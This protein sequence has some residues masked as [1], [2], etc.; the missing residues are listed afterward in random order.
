MMDDEHRQIEDQVEDP[1]S[2]SSVTPGDYFYTSTQG[3][4]QCCCDSAFTASCTQDCSDVDCDRDPFSCTDCAGADCRGLESFLGDG[5]CDDGGWDVQFNCSF[6][7][8]DA[9][10]CEAP[11]PDELATCAPQDVAECRRGRELELA[12]TDDVSDHHAVDAN[13]NAAAETVLLRGASAATAS[14]L[15]SELL[16]SS[17]SSAAAVLSDDDRHYSRQ[18][19]PRIVGGQEVCPS[20]AYSGFLVGISDGEHQTTAN[21]GD[22][23][24]G[25]TL[26]GRGHV[27]TAAHCV[28][29]KNNGG[30]DADDVKGL[31]VE[32]HRHDRTK[33]L[34][35]ECAVRIAV[36]GVHCHPDYDPDSLDSDIAVLVLAEEVPAEYEV[37]NVVLDTTAAF[38]ANGTTLIVTGW[39]A[40]NTNQSDPVYA[41]QTM[42]VEVEVIATSECTSSDWGYRARDLTD[43]MMCVGYRRGTPQDA[44]Q[45]S[46]QA[47]RCQCQCRCR[48]RCG[49]GCHCG[50]ILW[51]L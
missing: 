35:E 11:P 24:C 2:A 12:A 41:N 44:C 21:S 39:G 15:A 40:I 1:D 3:E 8:F 23:F 34:C 48:C 32:V 27:I 36:S 33:P 25:G 17:S 31:A 14:V 13:A 7:Y 26:Y 43:K 6:F 47:R 4:W 18:L 49:C 22:M 5:V 29:L 30:F 20:F 16:A 10:D 45:A 19:Q 28:C 51:Q 42:A 9:G 50:V 38:E 37:D 46:K